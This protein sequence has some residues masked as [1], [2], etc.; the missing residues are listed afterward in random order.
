ML[1]ESSFR[2]VGTGSGLT[3]MEWRKF[4]RNADLLFAKF[5]AQRLMNAPLDHAVLKKNDYLVPKLNAPH[6]YIEPL[7]PWVFS[8]RL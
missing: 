1:L 7:Y 4:F 5:F 2:E 3:D 6:H 8:H